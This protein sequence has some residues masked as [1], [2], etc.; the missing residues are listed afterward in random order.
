MGVLS[1]LSRQRSGPASRT[2]AGVNIRPRRMG[3]TLPA[4]YRRNW[5]HGDPVKTTMLDA[6]S[7]LLPMG[8]DFF[9]R[10]MRNVRE[11][12]TDPQLAQDAR[13]FCGQEGHHAFEHR[14]YNSLLAASGYPALPRIDAVQERIHDF[15]LRHTNP[16]D[17]IAFT[18]GAEHL[19]SIMA[20]AFLSDAQR[21][22]VDGDE[23][24]SMLFWHAVEEIEHKSVCID[25][26]QHLD[27]SYPR[28]IAGFALLTVILAG[29]MLSRQL[30]MLAVDGELRRPAT[31]ARLA[32]F[33]LGARYRDGG[34]G[35]LRLIG[36][37]YLQYLRPGFH[38][39]DEDDRHLVEKWVAA[40]ERGEAVRALRL[41]DVAAAPASRA[42]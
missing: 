27:D 5:S 26:L 4:G 8:E 35:V 2:P 6:F 7:C 21:W 38:P 42:A 37:D 16:I 23:F 19:T 40:F 31:W 11:R 20:N 29:G 9:L 34:P 39:W 10:A 28:R 30:Y 3:F 13:A 15:I 32:R 25:V 33:Y 24:S 14:K 1:R 18:A 36:R 12:I 22:V 17:H 41:A